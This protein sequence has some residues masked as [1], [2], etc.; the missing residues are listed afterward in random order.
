MLSCVRSLCQTVH[1]KR[2]I[3]KK[4]RDNQDDEQVNINDI[5]CSILRE[6]TKE[7]PKNRQTPKKPLFG[8]PTASESFETS[9]FG[10]KSKREEPSIEFFSPFGRLEARNRPT[11]NPW[12][13]LVDEPSSFETRIFCRLPSHEAPNEFFSPFSRL[14]DRNRPTQNPWENIVDQPRKPKKAELHGEEL[15]DFYCNRKQKEPKNNKVS[16]KSPEKK[17]TNDDDTL[18]KFDCSVC[19]E[20][21]K[22]RH[23]QSLK[24]GHI[25]CKSCIDTLCSSLHMMKCP[26]CQKPFGRADA[27]HVYV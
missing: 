20:P 1:F 10:T 14:E 19:L 2:F 8:H 5:I 24:C 4:S 22:N 23:P 9:I 11:E 27:R 18:L 26:V 3:M 12:E 6:S 21:M 16:K 17:L 15:L 25:F 13:N 7:R